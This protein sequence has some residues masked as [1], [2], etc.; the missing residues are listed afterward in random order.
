[1]SGEPKRWGDT[2]S[3]PIAAIQRER[4][5]IRTLGIAPRA[6]LFDDLKREVARS[7]AKLATEAAVTRA[8]RNLVARFTPGC[9]CGCNDGRRAR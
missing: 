8:E 7:L 5:R 6:P 4:D 2:S 3:N 9:P 1:M